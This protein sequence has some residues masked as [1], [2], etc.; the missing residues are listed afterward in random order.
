[1]AF[2]TYTGIALTFDTL[3]LTLTRHIVTIRDDDDRFSTPEAEAADRSGLMRGT[4]DGEAFVGG[5]FRTGE[6]TPVTLNDGTLLY[7]VVSVS[8]E[9]NG[10]TYFLLRD[11]V[12]P[13]DVR[14]VWDYARPTDGF[15]QSI[16]YTIYN[17][18]E[19]PTTLGNG[20]DIIA[21]GASDD[22][23]SLLGGDDYASGL[24][25]NDTLRGN[26]G[27][28]VLAGGLGLDRLLGGAGDDTLHGNA[29]RDRLEGGS[30]HDSLFGG[31]ANDT[32]F[33]GKGA[34]RL[35]D[36]AGA[37]RM[38]GQSGADVFV[39]RAD[40]ATDRIQDFRLGAD[41]IDLGL[42]FAVLEISDGDDGIVQI[43]HDG[44]LLLVR[45]VDGPLTAAQF[46][47]LDFL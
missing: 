8:Y 7:T 5:A 31:G 12:D 14:N 18:N 2:V 26:G 28:D 9:L 10:T 20:S 17:I 24:G 29:G 46:T 1:L 13:R 37:D 39:L 33:G 36:G 4:I 27:D 15:A 21:G 6:R 38:W 16:P 40:G 44:D 35:H 19:N 42:A 30:G 47:A 45:S 34:D 32:L 3:A 41:R 23:L 43:R 25:G 11:T 22:A